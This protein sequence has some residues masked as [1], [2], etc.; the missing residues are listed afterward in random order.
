MG[1]SLTERGI[2]WFEQENAFRIN[3]GQEGV[4]A[5]SLAGEDVRLQGYFRARR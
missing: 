1:T 3:E 5:C 2:V 4:R